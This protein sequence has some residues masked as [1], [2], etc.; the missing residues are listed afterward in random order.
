MER[1][2]RKRA[3]LYG[4]AAVLSAI[5]LGIAV[6][7][8]ATYILRDAVQEPSLPPVASFTIS[9]ASPYYISWINKSGEVTY[10]YPTLTFM[11]TSYDREGRITNYIWDF[12]D[13]ANCSGLKFVS[14]G[15]RF[16]GVYNVSLTVTNDKGL[17]SI[18]YRTVNVISVNTT[19]Y[20]HPYVISNVEVGEIFAVNISLLNVED[21][22]AWQAGLKVN[23]ETLEC[24]SF[25]KTS[26]T[27]EK[28]PVLNGSDEA[29]VISEGLFPGT[30]GKT[31]WITPK[32]NNTAGEIGP[33]A[34]CL[35]PWE[36]DGVSSSGSLATITFLVRNNE[37]SDL[38]LTDVLLLDS[39]GKP[40]PLNIS[41]GRFES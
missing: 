24:V 23:P 12:G 19:L 36:E 2:I 13:G 37:Q 31:I 38:E 22:G 33:A 11:S 16:P 17:N 6:D 1:K 20:V 5:V 21:L 10:D 28:H 29:F 30:P 39:V 14:Y 8:Y 15:Y 7:V 40:I 34:C 18:T 25:E 9:P 27:S 3:Q 35:A 26:A 4:I 41:Y 32:I